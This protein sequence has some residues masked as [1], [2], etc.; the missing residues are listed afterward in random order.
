M[1]KKKILC[2]GGSQ[3]FL[4]EKRGCYHVPHTSEWPHPLGP[5]T[6]S[7]VRMLIS[8]MTSTLPWRWENRGEKPGLGI[9]LPSP[10]IPQEWSTLWNTFYCVGNEK[11]RIANTLGNVKIKERVSE[12]KVSAVKFYQGLAFLFSCGTSADTFFLWNNEC[13]V[14]LTTCEGQGHQSSRALP[15]H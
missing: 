11:L 7:N 8:V 10:K 3:I 12:D 4:A 1:E 14:I 6:C 5:A 9:D 2:R 15:N 13:D